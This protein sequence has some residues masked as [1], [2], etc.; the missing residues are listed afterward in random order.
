MINI[1]YFYLLKNNV[2]IVLFKRKIVSKKVRWI[3]LADTK[4]YSETLGFGMLLASTGGFMDMYSYSVHGHVFA[5]GQTGNLVLVAFNLADRN[6][7]EMFHALVPIISFWIG[8]FISWY[9]FYSAFREKSLLW[10]RGILTV[11]MLALFIA[12]LIPS[13]YSDIFA[14]TLVSFAASL[15]YCAFRKLGSGDNYASIFCTGNMRSCADNYFKGIVKKDKACLK[16]ALRYS[17]ILISFFIGAVISSLEAGIFH[18]KSIWTVEII[19]I[20]GFIISFLYNSNIQKRI[21][22]VSIIK[23]QFDNIMYKLKT[24]NEIK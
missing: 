1:I 3:I 9:M 2:I 24:Q 11:S 4:N 15:Q 20:A 14:N 22:L 7:I 5:T 18:E 23:T 8:I 6:Y 16:K 21:A 10:Q 19:L 13:T 17:C 12:G